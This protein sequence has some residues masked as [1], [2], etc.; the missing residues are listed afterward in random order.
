L[1]ASLL[2]RKIRAF[3]PFPGA[4]A[5]LRQTPIKLWR[6]VAREGGGQPGSVLSVGVDG[7]DVACG[8]GVLRLLEL[9]KP[10]SKRL[11][12]VDFLQGFSVAGGDHMSLQEP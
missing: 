2:E 4:S 6:A 10:G 12:V 1:P 11:P 8:E 9:Q 7:I 5:Q 3:N